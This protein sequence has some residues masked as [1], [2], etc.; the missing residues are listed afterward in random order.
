VTFVIGNDHNISA[1]L[2]AAGSTIAS[3]LANE[4]SEASEPLY[5]SALIE[6]GLVLFV[7]TCFVQAAAQLWLGWMSR[8][9]GDGR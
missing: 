9:K 3:T 8:G 6:L 4:F 1:S 5:L 7:I 2:Y